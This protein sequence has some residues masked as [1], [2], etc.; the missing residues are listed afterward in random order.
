MKKDTLLNNCVVE[1]FDIGGLDKLG[2]ILL[3]RGESVADAV[4]G[5]ETRGTR[6]RRNT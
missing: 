1:G 5:E 3:E 2:A 4:E 6:R